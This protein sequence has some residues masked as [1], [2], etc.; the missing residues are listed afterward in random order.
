MFFS[1][2]DSWLIEAAAHKCAS[3]DHGVS[4]KGE[5]VAALGEPVW[6][7]RTSCS[8]PQHLCH[9]WP[10]C[11]NC[12]SPSIVSMLT[13]RIYEIGIGW[14]NVWIKVENNWWPIVCLEQQHF[15]FSCVLR[16]GISFFLNFI[17]FIDCNIKKC[18]VVYHYRKLACI[19][20]AFLVHCQTLFSEGIHVVSD[21]ELLLGGNAPLSSVQRLSWRTTEGF[22][23]EVFIIWS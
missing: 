9:C 19:D 10:Q 7:S 11:K 17:I 2:A 16:I 4:G 3:A 23:G 1:N 18:N 21:T 14:E 8:Q 12:C 15:L 22:T 6:G 5:D 13:S 20:C